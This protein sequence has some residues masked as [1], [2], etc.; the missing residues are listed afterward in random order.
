M[1]CVD[2]SAFLEMSGKLSERSEAAAIHFSITYVG[3]TNTLLLILWDMGQLQ[4]LTN[5]CSLKLN[6][7]EVETLTVFHQLHIKER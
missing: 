1:T 6:F 2:I 5:L 7:S 3:D 4:I